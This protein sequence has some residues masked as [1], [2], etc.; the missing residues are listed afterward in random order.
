MSKLNNKTNAHPKNMSDS[1][2]KSRNAS[3]CISNFTSLTV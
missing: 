3:I 2:Q 1:T